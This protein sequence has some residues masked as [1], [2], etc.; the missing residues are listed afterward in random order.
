VTG[1]LAVSAFAP[2]PAAEQLA[3]PGLAAA[4]FVASAADGSWDAG[5]AVPPHAEAPNAAS[6]IS[7]ILARRSFF[8]LMAPWMRPKN[9]LRSG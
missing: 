4:G 1:A 9:L 7:R 2:Q 8:I 3:S 6:V 5:V